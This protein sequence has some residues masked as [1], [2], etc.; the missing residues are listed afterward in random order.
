MSVG[1]YH[2]AVERMDSVY[3]LGKPNDLGVGQNLQKNHRS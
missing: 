1:I 3:P 2:V